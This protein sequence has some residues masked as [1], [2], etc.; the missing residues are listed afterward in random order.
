MLQR[1]YRFGEVVE[2][3]AQ[4]IGGVMYSIA[5]PI[6]ALSISR[7][8]VKGSLELLDALFRARQPKD[9]LY[10]GRLFLQEDT[11]LGDDNGD[12]A[13]DVTLAVLVEERYGDIGIGYALYEGHAK[14]AGQRLFFVV[15]LLRGA[16]A[17][18]PPPRGQVAARGC[19]LWSCDGGGL[20][21]PIAHARSVGVCLRAGG[22]GRRAEERR[23]S[24]DDCIAG[25]GAIAASCGVVLSRHRWAQSGQAAAVWAAAT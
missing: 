20:G 6:Q 12:I 24:P 19:R 8:G 13:V 2:V 23:S 14:D 3:T 11:A 1:Y 15:L 9:A 18:L 17:K 10:V 4:D 5:G 22:H 16:L 25:V 21:L 7:R